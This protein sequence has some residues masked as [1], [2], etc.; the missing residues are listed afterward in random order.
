MN[1]FTNFLAF[2]ITVIIFF[3]WLLPAYMLWHT[4]VGVWGILYLPIVGIS[5]AWG[6]VIT[7]KYFS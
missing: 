5:I 2:I 4:G 6:I 1:I 3:L 7:H